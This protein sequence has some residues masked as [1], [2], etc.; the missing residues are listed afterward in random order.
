[1]TSPAT[2]KSA[3][4]WFVLQLPLWSLLL[5][6][7]FVALLVL[8]IRF[9]LPQLD[10]TRPDL[11][12]WLNQQLPFSVHS[13]QLTASLY[14]IDPR[15]VVDELTLGHQ[16]QDFL[17]L[18]QFEAEMDSWASL[19]A[20]APR[21]QEV[22]L[23][24]LEIWLE[25]TARGWQLAGWEGRTPESVEQD[26]SQLD[27]LLEWLELLLVQGELDFADITLNLKPLAGESLQ[28]TAPHLNYRRWSQGRQ[29]DFQLGLEGKQASSRLLITLEGEDFDLQESRLDAWLNLEHLEVEDLHSLWPASLQEQLGLPQ[30]RVSLQAWLSLDEG[31]VEV[32]LRSQEGNL[33]LQPGN[34]AFQDLALSLSG[35]GENWQAD[36]QLADLSWSGQSLKSLQ[37]QLHYDPQT[38]QVIL[39]SLPL[40]EA[41][42]ALL[43]LPQPPGWLVRLLEDLDPQG[44]L[45]NLHLTWGDEQP[46]K[47]TSLLQDVTVGAWSGA[48]GVDNLNAWLEATAEGGRVVFKPQPLKLFFPDLYTQPFQLSSGQGE[49]SWWL[50]QETVWVEG[51]KLLAQLP[52]PEPQNPQQASQVSGNFSLQL[53]PQDD[54]LYLNLGLQPTRLTA[55]RQL[56]PERVLPDEVYSWLQEALQEG[57]VQ[58][59]G[60]IFAGSLRSNSNPNFQFQGDFQDAR[61]AFDP[62]WPLLN[63]LDG[64]VRVD[65]GLTQGQVSRGRL[66]DARLQQA[67]FFTRWQGREQLL[68]VQAQISSELAEFPKLIAQSPLQGWVPEALHSWQYQGRSEGSLE[69]QIPF[70]EHSD[71]LQ[72]D[73]HLD[74]DEGRL[75]LSQADLQLDALQG[76]LDFNLDQGLEGSRLAGRLW[77]QP[78]EARIQGQENRLTFAMTPNLTNILNWLEWPSWPWA[79][80]AAAVQGEWVLDP[81][82]ALEIHSILEGVSLDLPEPFGKSAPQQKPLYLRLDFAEEEIPLVLQVGDQLQVNSQLG[83]ENQGIRVD[84][85]DQAVQSSGLPGEPGV[86]VDAQLDRVDLDLLWRWWQKHY[87]EGADAT[88]VAGIEEA[89]GLPD[90]LLPAELRQVTARITETSW[91]QTPLGPL[92]LNLQHQQPDIQLQVISDPLIGRLHWQNPDSRVQLDLDRLKL[93][94][95]KKPTQ[96]E[97]D[98]PYFPGSRRQEMLALRPEDFLEGSQPGQW[99]DLD[100]SVASL[101][102]GQKAWGRWQG[103]VRTDAQQLALTEV[104]GDLGQSRVSGE[105][106]WRLKPQSSSRLEVQIQGKDP[107][108]A[109]RAVT[110]A[111]SPLVS[112]SHAMEGQFTWPG[113]PAAFLL[114]RVD[115]EIELLFK[116]GYFPETEGT[117]L[118]A[119]RFFGLMNLDN[120]VRRMRLDFSDLTTEGVSFDRLEASYQL[121][122]GY[123]RSL[124]PAL[125]QSSATRVSLAGEIDLLE[126]TLDQELKVTLPVGQT[127]PL[128]A[129]ALGAPQIGA[130]IWLG[131]KFL[132]LFFD[133]RREALYE[134]RGSI[135]QPEVKLKEL[136]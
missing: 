91:Q 17:Q 110:A 114:P 49:V 58:Q 56:V 20:W 101:E 116:K 134:V 12:A 124:Q 43:E 29:L 84:L 61:L 71:D 2:Q 81:L 83:D 125:M 50:D 36:W 118:G 90:P 6:L 130:A 68:K 16:G 73:L 57:Q 14:R 27:Q 40:V 37:G 51:R 59:G 111:K 85:A 105:L 25:E 63:H 55:H 18:Q 95:K 115:G 26:A 7:V 121:E 100:W 132:G 93:P 31:R 88:R 69:L 35:Q 1:M 106:L 39:K 53:H 41:K 129:V 87:V 8:L 127:L 82:S 104:Q 13:Q 45:Q 120:L 103:V 96:S 60:F 33:E 136:R 67:D 94:G 126:E 21:M 9:L 89:E 112:E 22:Q 11:E 122:E 19:L 65:Q 80:G 23:Q 15:L 108:P 24:G 75:Y 107:A 113:S 133:T 92:Y 86:R 28:L 5:L 102:Q 44:H 3:W 32:E 74:V 64:W 98:E 119:S 99:P 10:S 77:E 42:L 38:W 128:A 4:R 131:Q 117:A 30:G 123:L 97:S 135:R 48:P 79:E 54:R 34:L 52:L 62:D 76:N 66:L 70:Y 78:F 46:W 72:V 47:I 109:L